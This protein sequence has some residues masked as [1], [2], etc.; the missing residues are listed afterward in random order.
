MLPLIESDDSNVDDMAQT[1]YN[2]GVSNLVI[3][4]GVHQ[5][6]LQTKRLLLRA[7]APADKHDSRR[8][9]PS[10]NYWII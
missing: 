2:A 4:K 7:L 3:S 8:I 10:R 1:V 5:M 9:Y 6:Q